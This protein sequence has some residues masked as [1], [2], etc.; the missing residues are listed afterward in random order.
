MVLLAIVTPQIVMCKIPSEDREALWVD[1][2]F[3]YQTKKPV[4]QAGSGHLGGWRV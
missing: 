2:D 1:E 3:L 4:L